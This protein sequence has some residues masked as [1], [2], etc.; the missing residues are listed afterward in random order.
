MT[1]LDINALTQETGV[2]DP[3][4]AY[5]FPKWKTPDKQLQ[6]GYTDQT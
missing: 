5:V 2:S 3:G 1:Y 4:T 6:R